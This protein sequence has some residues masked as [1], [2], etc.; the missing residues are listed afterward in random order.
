[1]TDSRENLLPQE[2][3]QTNETATTVDDNQK[4]SQRKLYVTKADVLERLDQMVEENS[5]VDKE[6]LEVLK[7]VFYKN[8][9]AERQ[10]AREAFVEAGGA[11]EDYKP[12][13]DM[14]EENFKRQMSIIKEQRAKI[15]ENQEKQKQENL[16][17]KLL[18]IEKIKGLTSTPEEANSHYDAFKALQAEWKEIKNIPAEK[19]NELWKNYQLCVEQYYDLLKLNSEMRA[20]DFKKNL[21]I[22]TRLC[23]TAEKLTKEPDVV[24]AFRHLQELHVE[25]RE[26]GPVAK[27][28]R[29]DIWTRFKE[30]S[31]IINKLHTA[32]FENLKGKEEENLAKKTAFCEKLEAITTDELRTFAQWDARTK[33]ILEIQNEWRTVGPTSKKTNTKIF[34][35]FRAACD[36]F[37]TKKANHFKEQKD[38]YA[39]NLA[40]KVKICETAEELKES[41]DWNSTTNK[42]IALQKEWKAVG[43][44]PKKISDSV[45][46]RFNQACNTFFENKNAALGSQRKEENENLDKKKEVIEKLKE[47]L[48]SAEEGAQQDVRSLM[49]EWNAIGHVPFKE[50]D[51]VYKA[52]HDVVDELFK[53]LNMISGRRKIDSFKSNLQDNAKDGS[54]LSQ[55]RNRIF[56]AY[57]AKKAEINTYENNLGFLSSN[58]KSGNS[59]VNELQKKVNRLKDDLQLLSEKIA[60]IDSQMKETGN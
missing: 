4:N 50:K 43:P 54:S 36:A 16:Q 53:K 9:N 55:E 60:V 20:Y 59:L 6:E 3:M 37:F 5:N 12:E 51:N 14:D 1:M 56:R 26:T 46:M 2:I 42:I 39:A 25:F 34:E 29:E 13:I 7:Q 35:R 41:K 8:L 49:D 17:K 21:E 18:I 15:Q 38:T 22:K 27:E 48:S 19:S 23:E 31:T 11:P 33:E 57:E 40:A 32:Y 52:Y 30:A 47:L 10:A 44:V 24:A 28:L 58:S 45:W